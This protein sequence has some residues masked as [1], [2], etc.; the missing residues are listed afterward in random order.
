MSRQFVNVGGGAGMG[1][2]I[3]A[4]L[5]THVF[6]D[7]K[8]DIGTGNRIVHST[9]HGAPGDVDRKNGVEVTP[10]QKNCSRT[11]IGPLRCENVL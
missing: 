11:E 8:E 2:T 10:V 1:I 7:Q 4:Q 3:T 6:G 5:Q 9:D